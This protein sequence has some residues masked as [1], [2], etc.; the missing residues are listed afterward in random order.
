MDS[1]ATDDHRFYLAG[2]NRDYQVAPAGRGWKWA[3]ELLDEW[4]LELKD[5]SVTCEGDAWKSFRSDAAAGQILWMPKPSAGFSVR[6]NEKLKL[7]GPYRPPP[8][9]AVT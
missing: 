7:L 4:K 2:D 8:A 9:W 3:Y 1:T 6:F 5:A